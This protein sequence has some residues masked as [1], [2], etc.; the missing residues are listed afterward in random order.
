MRSS[1]AS[2]RTSTGWREGSR[3]QASTT[4]WELPAHCPREWITTTPR[5]VMGLGIPMRSTNPNENI[6]LYGRER[7]GQRESRRGALSWALFPAK[8]AA[9]LYAILRTCPSTIKS[10]LS[11]QKAQRPAHTFFNRA[12]IPPH[13]PPSISGSF[14]GDLR[15]DPSASTAQLHSGAAPLRKRARQA[16]VLCTTPSSPAHAPA[17]PASTSTPTPR[18][19]HQKSYGFAV[20]IPPCLPPYADT[21]QGSLFVVSSTFSM[22]RSLLF[23]APSHEGGT[24]EGG[25]V[26]HTRLWHTHTHREREREREIDTHTQFALL[27]AACRSRQTHGTRAP[28]YAHGQE[29]TN[30]I[31]SPPREPK[32][33]GEA[34]AGRQAQGGGAAFV[35]R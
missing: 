31:P 16:C 8:A 12:S 32:T 19:R 1:M 6:G 18:A 28:G 10:I 9:G 23:W 22:H 34:C 24:G 25:T 5:Y 3:K 30:K 35:I 15:H 20:L 21:V 33:L 2:T 7:D 4:H 26:D 29:P 17:V 14:P 11:L 27:A 13:H